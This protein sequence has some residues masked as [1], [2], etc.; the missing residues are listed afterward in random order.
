M[1]LWT[2]NEHPKKA[3]E[4]MTEFTPLMGEPGQNMGAPALKQG[5]G[6]MLDRLGGALGL[7]KRILRSSWP[8]LN[9]CVDLRFDRTQ[10]HKFL[11]LL[12]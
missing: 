5:F 3:M 7:M 4:L 1:E 12:I 6:T 2:G 10:S 9:K 11:R 8:V